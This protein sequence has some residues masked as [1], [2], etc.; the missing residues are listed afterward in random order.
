[1]DFVRSRESPK[2]RVGKSGR[3]C[4][5]CVLRLSESLHASITAL[6]GP[7]RVG[8]D[9]KTGRQ[10][11]IRSYFMQTSDGLACH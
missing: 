6:P 2:N 1:M 7:T 11:E 3:K 5:H 10:P 8:S 9:R 4:E